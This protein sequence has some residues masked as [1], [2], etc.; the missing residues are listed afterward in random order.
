[1]NGKHT[2]CRHLQF[3]KFHKDRNALALLIHRGCRRSSAETNRLYVPEY[4]ATHAAPSSLLRGR[5]CAFGKVIVLLLLQL[6][7]CNVMYSY[8]CMLWIVCSV[9]THKFIEG[10][11]VRDAC[12]L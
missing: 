11:P 4:K 6:M 8:C 5:F 2:A 1:M 7:R 3:R 12:N 10:L 9:E